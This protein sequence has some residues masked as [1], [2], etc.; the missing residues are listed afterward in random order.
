MD[1]N[2]GTKPFKPVFKALPSKTVVLLPKSKKKVSSSKEKKEVPSFSSTLVESSKALRSVEDLGLVPLRSD[3]STESDI[4]L[5]DTTT[6]QVFFI[7][8]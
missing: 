1:L 8:K 5:E 6:P 7:I 4:E 2:D 3:V